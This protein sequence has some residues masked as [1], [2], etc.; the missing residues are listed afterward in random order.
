MGVEEKKSKLQIAGVIA[1]YWFVSISLV[2]INKFIVSRQAD[3]SDGAENK[4]SVPIFIT[5]SQVCRLRQRKGR[6]VDGNHGTS[7]SRFGVGVHGGEPRVWCCSVLQHACGVRGWRVLFF[8]L[9]RRKAAA[10]FS[11]HSSS[12]REQEQLPDPSALCPSDRPKTGFNT[13]LQCIVTCVICWVCGMMGEKERGGQSSADKEKA[14]HKPSASSFLAAFPKARYD[15]DAALKVL[16]LS[17][18]FVLMIVSN[19]LCLKY[20]EVSFYNV[21]R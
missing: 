13:D 15:R 3:P 9:Q 5:W 7:T 2:Y 18:I 17:L 6:G 12:L 16:P 11:L 20:V 10:P 8:P 21:A 4:P 1:L 14:E 19:Q